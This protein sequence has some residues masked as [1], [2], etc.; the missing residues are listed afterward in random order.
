M[1]NLDAKTLNQFKERYEADKQSLAVAGAIAK[2]GLNDA[3][4]NPE[5]LRRHTFVFSGRS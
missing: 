2:V 4:V 3:S 1:L 5:V